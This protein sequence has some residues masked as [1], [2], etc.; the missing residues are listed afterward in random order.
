MPDRPAVAADAVRSRRRR[1]IWALAAASVVL[2]AG[3]VAIGR[4]P[5]TVELTEDD[6]RYFS[7]DNVDITDIDSDA[8]VEIPGGTFMMGARHDLPGRTTESAHPVTVPTF[9]ISRFEITNEQY[10]EYLK[11]NPRAPIPPHLAGANFFSTGRRVLRDT[12]R[13]GWERHPV[14]N[15]TWNEAVEYVNWLNEQV[16]GQIDLPTDA[17]WEYAARGTEGRKY[18]WGNSSPSPLRANY[19]SRSGPMPSVLRIGPTAGPGWAGYRVEVGSYPAGATPE[20]VYDLAGNVWEWVADCTHRGGYEDAPDDGSEWGGPTCEGGRP[21]AR[22]LRGGSWRSGAPLLEAARRSGAGVD[23]DHDWYGFRVVW[24]PEEEPK[25]PRATV[26]RPLIHYPERLN[27]I[28][29][30]TYTAHFET[31]EGLVIIEVHRS[32]APHGADRFYNLVTNGFYDGAPIYRVIEGVLAQW[33]LNGDPEVDRHWWYANLTKDSV[34]VPNT[35]GRVAIARSFQGQRSTE[36]HINYGDNQFLNERDPDFFNEIGFAPFGEVVQGM[37]VV[38]RFYSGYGD[39]PPDGNGPI[40]QIAR[41]DGNEYFEE[42]PELSRIVR[43][44]V[45][46]DAR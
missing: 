16:E 9:R 33:G 23:E 25:P 38:D 11:A 30:E 15:V 24:R 37:D 21:H 39:W 22:V 43:A 20:G 2:I 32:W 4:N 19:G 27:E 40:Q 35:R 41:R 46:T 7:W 17:E 12:I 10:L 42:F 36:V 28:A 34:L 45:E 8:W 29:P 18:P 3:W 5:R 6:P 14:T 1:W 31:T 13:F 44:W 26:L